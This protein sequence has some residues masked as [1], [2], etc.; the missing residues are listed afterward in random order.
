MN[1]VKVCQ[2]AIAARNVSIPGIPFFLLFALAFPFGLFGQK[3]SAVQPNRIAGLLDPSHMI[4]LKGNIHPKARLENDLGPASK[5]LT[6]D[7][8]TLYLKPTA[9]QQADLDEFLGQLQARS[10]PNYHRWLTPEQYADRFG[11]SPADLAQIFAWLEGQGL[12]VI[13][14]AR[15]RNFVVFKGTVGKVEGALHVKVHRFLV[16]GEV[17]LANATE[18]SVP[19]AIQSFTT[20]FSGLD[21]FRPK[22]PS[23][24][25]RPASDAVFNN[26]H[27]L[28]P[29]DLWTIY[30]T[31]PLYNAGITGQGM[32][33]AVM[34]QSNVNLSDI[35]AYQAAVGLA[36][37]P[38]LKLLV[39][40]SLDPG[41][42]PDSNEADL[43]LE[44]AGAMAPS[45]QILFV[46]SNGVF[47]SATYAIDHA[48]A[49]VIS[50]SYAVCEMNASASLAQLYRQLAQQANAEGITWI[51][52]SGDTGA[53]ACDQQNAA[54][55][56]HNI[57]VM[58]PASVPEV[59]GVGGTEFNEGGG[60]Y[61]GSSNLNAPSYI[62]EVA[63]NETA[64]VGLSASGGGVS[65]N[66]PR[67]TWQSAPGVPAIN[68]RLVPDLAM[69]AAAQHDP[70]FTV[71]SGSPGGHG[72]TS[73]SAPLFAAI[74]LLLAQASG[75]SGFGNINPA[76]YYL[77]SNPANVCNANAIT[78]ACVFHD[79]TAGNNIVPCVAGTVGCIGG[80][81]GYTAAG[82]YDVVT[83]LGSIDAAKLAHAAATQTF[84]PII[85][86]VS[87]AYAGPA[88]AQNTFLVIKGANLVPATTP[89]NGVIWSSASSFASGL[90][91]TQ[92]NGVSVTVNNKPAFVYFYCSAATD[93]NCSQDQLNILTPLDDATGPVPVVVTSG[94]VS[95]PP[96]MAN[97]QAVAPSFLLFSPAGYV[98][99]THANGGL[100]GPTNLYP[101]SSTPASPGE[102]I[103]VYAVGFGLP[104][105]PLANGSSTQSGS[106]AA[107][108]V[109]TLGGNPATVSFA[110]LISPGLYQL[111][112]TVPAS[113]A[114]ADNVLSCSYKGFTTPAGDVI[115]VQ[116]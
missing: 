76:L 65:I 44:L 28:A 85:S 32:K 95:S 34:G 26:Q 40:G 67:P 35:A 75:G 97:M 19:A 87:T 37:N 14:K 55:A 113:A 101:G 27:V 56:S 94:T 111:N 73:A 61:W 1:K 112:L 57:S 60:S 63:W 12:S 54:V 78:A 5:D 3:A 52:S 99:A 20:G 72:G 80:L 59:T 108:P 42:T 90:M 9:A 33:L 18:P 96:F 81:M 6:L 93:A 43:D 41:L 16:D 2:Q 109:C 24:I 84:G 51:A 82:G 66:F 7:Y 70:Y 77:A 110:G 102:V 29:K 50:Y 100:V 71:E 11:A 10:S 88:T 45:A 23:N 47:N 36:A 103:V 98:A 58:L 38:P 83:G 106:L 116:R 31:L 17:H 69:A 53:A 13:N 79:V 30:D 114:S 104:S 86:S 25:G 115:A 22:P 64:I 62:P 91:P 8:I 15:G 4:E 49:P 74:V 105:K 92:L 107:T 89:A 21:D 68:A 39:P 48:V 46:Y